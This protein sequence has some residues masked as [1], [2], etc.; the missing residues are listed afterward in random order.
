MWK[1]DSECVK[2]ILFWKKI[3]IQYED[4]NIIFLDDA[5]FRTV[6]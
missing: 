6:A 5:N 3:H 2:E 1:P 4:M